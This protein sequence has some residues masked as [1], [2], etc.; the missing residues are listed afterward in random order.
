MFKFELIDKNP[1]ND[2][3]LSSFYKR[4]VQGKKS[5]RIEAGYHVLGTGFG[6]SLSNIVN[7]FQ[8]KIISAYSSEIFLVTDLVL[9][10]SIIVMKC[11]K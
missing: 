1:I 2:S 10:E 11:Y 4:Q 6:A 3:G 8:S 9:N 5:K 7:C